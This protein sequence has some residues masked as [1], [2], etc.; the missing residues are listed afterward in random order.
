MYTTGFC[1]GGMEFSSRSLFL[2]SRSVFRSLLAC[3]PPALASAEMAFSSRVLSTLRCLLLLSRSVFRSLLT[4]GYTTAVLFQ[5]CGDP[6]EQEQ[7][8]SPRCVPPQVSFAP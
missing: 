6:Q 8:R 2:L 5:G 7:G 1:V 4:L 3:I